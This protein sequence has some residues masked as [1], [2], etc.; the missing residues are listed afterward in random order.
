VDDKLLVVDEK[1]MKTWTLAQ[2]YGAVQAKRERER[3]L[4]RNLSEESA[5]VVLTRR[6]RSLLPLL[7]LL[8]WLLFDTAALVSFLLC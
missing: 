3:E 7:H 5:T 1:R 4:A 2:D 6:W 8:L